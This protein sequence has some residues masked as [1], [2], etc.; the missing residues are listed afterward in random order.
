M[1][2]VGLRIYYIQ[3]TNV[4]SKKENIHYILQVPSA[5]YKISHYYVVESFGDIYQIKE[6]DN[7]EN[8]KKYQEENGLLCIFGVDENGVC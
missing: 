5:Q 1:K 7:V 4:F 3:F 8:A 6:F 2:D